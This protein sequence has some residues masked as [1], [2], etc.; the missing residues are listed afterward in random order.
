MSKSGSKLPHKVWSGYLT[1]G[2]V[3][4]PVQLF[5][6]AREERI[7]FNKLH[8]G[9][10]ARLKQQSMTCSLCGVVPPESEIVKGYEYDKNTF[11]T[12]T[13]EEIEAAQPESART[14][15]ITEFVSDQDVDPVYFESSFYLA[16]SEG[17][18]KC[19]SLVREAMSFKGVVAIAKMVY[20]GKEH[21]CIVRAIPGGLMVHTLF[22]ADEVRTMLMPRLPEASDA[23]LSIAGQLI[24]ALHKKWDPTRYRDNYRANIYA[25]IEDKKAGKITAPAAAPRRAPA[26]VIDITAALQ[27]SIQKA[28]AATAIAS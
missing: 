17:G 3:S 8:A 13:P 16:A 18:E 1:F 5:T 9:C 20:S 27:A 4:M 11:V 15:E 6:A 24:D 23:E 12:L 21:V 19:F 7:A 25:L 28:R 10:N 22:W 2:L 14:M 26:P